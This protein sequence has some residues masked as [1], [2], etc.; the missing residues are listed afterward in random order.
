[1]EL[2]NKNTNVILKQSIFIES[3]GNLT[4][5]LMILSQ[6]TSALILYSLLKEIWLDL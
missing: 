3:S 2:L 5:V 4:S 1:M 6:W